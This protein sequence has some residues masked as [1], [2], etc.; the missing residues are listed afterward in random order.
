MQPVF[1]LELESP[2]TRANRAN[3]LHSTGPRTDLG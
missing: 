1:D 3:A 2:S